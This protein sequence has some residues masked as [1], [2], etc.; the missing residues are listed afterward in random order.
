MPLAVL[1][2]LVPAVL[3]APVATG[4][5]PAGRTWRIG[6]L[7]ARADPGEDRLYEAVGQRRRELW[8]SSGTRTSSGTRSC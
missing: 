7:I 3:L 5:Q 2:S 8:V 4:A 6:V 1:L